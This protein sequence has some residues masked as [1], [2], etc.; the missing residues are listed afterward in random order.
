MAL[1]QQ[2]RQQILDLTQ[3][4]SIADIQLIQNLWSGYGQLLRLSLNGGKYSSVIVKYIAIPESQLAA[5]PHPKGWNTELSHQRKVN[6]YQVEYAWYKEFAKLCSSE[7]YLPQCLLAEKQSNNMLLVLED[8]H[9]KG[10]D[11]VI[12]QASHSHISACLYWLGQFQGHFLWQQSTA[13]KPCINDKLWQQG[14]YWHL[15]T[16]PDELAALADNKL[17]Q[18]AHQI[19]ALLSQCDYQ[20][21]V[22]GDAKLANFCFNQQGTQAAAVDF[23]YVGYGCGMKD[24]ALFLSSVLT[25]DE[26]DEQV[27]NYLKLYF[28][29]L[30]QA[31]K[32]HQGI[33]LDA[34]ESSWR[35][36]FPVA[37]ADFQRFIKG[38]SPQHVKINP[39]TERLTQQALTS[40]PKLMAENSE[41]LGNR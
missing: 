36:L 6:S 35:A 37:W 32:Q 13:D 29:S 30:R 20:T 10:F 3:A 18:A 9:T 26:T 22:H 27:E 11:K 24:V 14:G 28:N 12:S 17:K 39:F 5:K 38:W 25:F 41:R 23:Q 40:L 15:A 19:D 1:S 4:N 21:I 8:L 34:L 33:E 2:Q 31:A 16:R 7:S